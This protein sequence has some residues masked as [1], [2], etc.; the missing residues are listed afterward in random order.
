MKR[1]FVEWL[2][3]R[4]SKEDKALDKIMRMKHFEPY[5]LQACIRNQ[6]EYNRNGFKK[7]I[8]DCFPNG[9][10]RLPIREFKAFMKYN[11]ICKIIKLNEKT[12]TKLSN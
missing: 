6:Y 4:P 5:F 8:I 10:V 7:F 11:N 1:T 12:N 2:K 3:T 9:V